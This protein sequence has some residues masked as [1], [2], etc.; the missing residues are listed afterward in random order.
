[1][2]R[3]RYAPIWWR[4]CSAGVPGL[5]AMPML[6]MTAVARVWPSICP[7]ALLNRRRTPP[8]G[9]PAIAPDITRSSPAFMNGAPLRS[10]IRR[11]VRQDRC[12]S[13]PCR[14]SMRAIILR[15]MT[16]GRAG[17]DRDMTAS[18]RAFI[19]ASNRVRMI[20]RQADVAA[21]IDPRNRHIATG[22]IPDSGHMMGGR[23]DGGS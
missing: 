12:T 1:M 3:A 22:W 19:S 10:T 21:S 8:P 13:G 16:G 23:P 6:Q 11:P 4:R 20:R 14:S 18:C 17:H 2:R 9:A 5:P 7:N 15:S